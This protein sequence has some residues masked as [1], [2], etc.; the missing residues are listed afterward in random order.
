M[1]QY[2][3][4]SY[5]SPLYT[6]L[7]NVECDLFDEWIFG[8]TYVTGATGNQNLTPVPVH[9]YRVLA[10]AAWSSGQQRFDFKWNTTIKWTMGTTAYENNA[11]I[12]FPYP[13]ME[14]GL[15][16]RFKVDTIYAP[17]GYVS[18]MYKNAI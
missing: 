18:L 5:G 14:G 11:I 4:N 3:T 6:R 9:K 15:N 10:I 8:R 1:H 13:G 2:V 7:A 17:V 16:Q 12:V